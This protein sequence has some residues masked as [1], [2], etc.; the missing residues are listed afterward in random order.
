MGRKKQVKALEVNHPVN[1]KGSDDL[2][3]NEILTVVA[4]QVGQLPKLIPGYGNIPIYELIP[5]GKEFT[6]NR[7]EYE[8]CKNW[9]SIKEVD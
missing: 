3:V 6:M 8:Q 7:D 5:K 9:V 1:D 2:V 4:T